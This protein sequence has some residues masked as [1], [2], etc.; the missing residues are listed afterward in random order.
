VQ[1]LVLNEETTHVAYD[2]QTLKKFEFGV[3][4]DQATKEFVFIRKNKTEI[5]RVKIN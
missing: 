4:V 2:N 3:Y 5:E 1:W